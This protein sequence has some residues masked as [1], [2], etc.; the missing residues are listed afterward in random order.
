MKKL[1][2]LIL[3]LA[4]AA[5]FFAGCDYV[6]ETVSKVY[7]NDAVMDTVQLYD[8]ETEIRSMNIKVNAA[9]VTIQQADRFF[10]QT[11]LR[12][13]KVTENAGVLHILEDVDHV[14]GYANAM[15]TI[16][17]PKDFVFE[18]LSV[19]TTAAKLNADRLCTGKLK[20]D[21]G[22]GDTRIGYLSAT[23]VAEIEGGAGLITVDDGRLHNLDVE[24]D[25]GNLKLTSA[26]KGSCEFQIGVG[27]AD[28]TLLGAK[29]DHTLEL[30]K[31]VGKIRIDGTE[32]TDFGIQGSG[33]THVKIKGSVGTVDLKF[34]Q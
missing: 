27:G 6:E 9:E 31:G 30:K 33:Q 15:L 3:V 11:N 26:L 1:M 25:V 5:A 13:V 4:M 20:L 19:E 34:K 2:A 23:T 32:V 21:M 17:Y 7:V 12:Y 28:I 16:Y 8:V 18:N 29:E 24:L 10:V 22:T 14:S